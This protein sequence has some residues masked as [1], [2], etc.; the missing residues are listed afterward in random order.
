SRIVGKVNDDI[1]QQ[2]TLVGLGVDELRSASHASSKTDLDRLYDQISV[3]SKA[4][5]DLSHN[6]YPF[7]LEYLGL[8]GALK[9]L[10]RDTAAQSGL[11][12]SFSEKDL[13]SSLPSDI[14]HCL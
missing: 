8:A 12:I 1:V 4:T 14:S 3:V 13:R 6:L 2:L 11:A 5:R 7:T 9:K 10:C